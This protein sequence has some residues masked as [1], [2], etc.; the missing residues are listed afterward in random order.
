MPLMNTWIKTWGEEEK[1]FDIKMS[2]ELIWCGWNKVFFH[3][4]WLFFGWI[5]LEK[6]QKKTPGKK[7]KKKHRSSWSPHERTCVCFQVAT[8]TLA[9]WLSSTPRPFIPNEWP[10]CLDSGHLMLAPPSAHTPV[11]HCSPCLYIPHCYCS[12]RSSPLALFPLYC[13]P[14]S[15]ESWH[16]LSCPGP[17]QPTAESLP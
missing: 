9:S 5:E 17:C 15:S 16:W 2:V 1:D 4:K 10:I 14:L 6:I 12:P 13:R 7:K 8:W 3:L 11:S